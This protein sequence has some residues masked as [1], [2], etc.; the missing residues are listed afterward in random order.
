M[1]RF[2]LLIALVV[3]SQVF[4]YSKP[5]L[6]PAEIFEVGDS[7]KEFLARIDTGAANSSLHAVDLEVEGGASKIKKHDIGKTIRFNTENHRGEHSTSSGKIVDVSTVKNAQGIESRYMVELALGFDGD[8]RQVKVNLR[9]RTHMDYKLLIGRNWVKGHYLVDVEEK[10]VIGAKAD[11]AIIESDLIYEAR[12]DTG[13]VETSLHATELHI[14]DEDTDNMDNNIGKIIRFKTS[15]EDGQVA[16]VSTKIV[17]TSLIRNSQGSEVRYMVN[18]TLGEPGKEYT[19]KVNLRDRTQMSQ[20]L[21]IGRNWL[22]GHYVVDVN[23]R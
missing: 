5:V 15:N 18:L 11:I 6:G 12:I 4:A 9:D 7:A 10:P 13:A 1:R 22:S 14:V 3:S 17:D 23:K 20:K 16:T 19:V 21:L 8:V 2:I